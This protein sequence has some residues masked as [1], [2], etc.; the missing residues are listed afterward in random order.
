[1]SNDL[2]T[3]RH[4][5]QENIRLRSENSGVKSHLL[6]VQQGIRALI[7]LQDNLDTITS[8]THVYSL[9]N[10]ILFA[11]LNAV[12][13]TDG[14]LLLMDDETEELVF[15][16]VIGEA[17]DTLMNY[18]ISVNDG[19]VGWV[20]RNKEPRLVEDVKRSS[21][22]SS[23]VDQDTGFKTTSLICVPLVDGA[24]VLGVLEV[25][26]TRTGRPFGE[27]DMDIMILVA[28]LASIAIARL[29]ETAASEGG[30]TPD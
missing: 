28:R 5:Q 25:V 10:N 27:G 20:A 16:D 12:D 22:F 19:V 6:R 21:M 18:R 30:N 15:V 14:S 11:A 1:M 8:D 26:N 29:E 17:R 4:L 7:D 24:R 13:S 2:Q 23:R 9:L 3:M